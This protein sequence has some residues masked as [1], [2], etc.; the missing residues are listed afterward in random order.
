MCSRSRFHALILGDRIWLICVLLFDINSIHQ[1]NNEAGA[2][3]YRLTLILHPVHVADQHHNLF[4][5][6]NDFGIIEYTQEKHFVHGCVEQLLHRI[7]YFSPWIPI[8]QSTCKLFF[9]IVAFLINAIQCSLKNE[10]IKQWTYQ[11]QNDVIS[12]RKIALETHKKQ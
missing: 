11:K 4:S 3:R 1:S 6:Y 9:N 10:K 7:N 2:T 5:L 8:N 12:R